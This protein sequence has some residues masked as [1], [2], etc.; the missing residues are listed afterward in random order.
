MPQC[1]VYTDAGATADDNIDGDVTG[2]IMTTGL[3]LDT[4]QLGTFTIA[5][6]V[7]DSAG[8]QAVNKRF[9]QVTTVGSECL[10]PPSPLPPNPPPPSPPSPSPP[11][12][13]PPPPP[14]PPPPLDTDAPI[15]TVIGGGQ[16]KNNLV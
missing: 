8:N 3:P 12:P 10:P 13:A 1:S 7:T 16:T 14:T 5:Y 9:V 4:S 2:D 11:P 6:S 15:I